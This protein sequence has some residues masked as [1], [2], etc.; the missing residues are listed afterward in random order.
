MRFQAGF[1]VGYPHVGTSLEW[2][3]ACDG[4]RGAARVLPQAGVVQV[5]TVSV[6]RVVWRLVTR[7]ASCPHTHAVGLLGT[8][9]IQLPG[10]ANPVSAY[11]PTENRR[12]ED[13]EA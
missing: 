11:T 10:D 3:E 2:E 13:L 9:L 8:W 6:C 4:Q 5:P 7:G 1:S 12:K